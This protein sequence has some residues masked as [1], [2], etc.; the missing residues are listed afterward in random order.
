MLALSYKGK[1]SRKN[2]KL[3]K[4]NKHT[5]TQQKRSNIHVLE[6]IH[7]CDK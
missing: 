5:T 7:N 4:E 2:E 3:F 1:I 6:H